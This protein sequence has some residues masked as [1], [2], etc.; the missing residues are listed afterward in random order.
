M[1]FEEQQVVLITGSSRGLGRAFASYLAAAGARVIVNSTGSNDQGAALV[2]ELLDRGDTAAHVTGRVDSAPDDLIDQAAAQWGRL[3]AVVHNAGIVR[4]KT[5][6]KMSDS[7]WDEVQQV[8]LR[9]AFQLSR[10]A[11]P[12]FEAQG[13]GSLVF[14][15]SAA[16]LYGN[17]GQANYAAAKGGLDGLCR[18]IA[19]EGAASN[20]R[21]NTVAP[22]GA[23][24]LNSGAWDDAR[25]A[26]LKTEYVAPL[27]GYLC[28]PACTASGGLFE[29]SAGVFKQVRWERSIGLSLNVNAPMTLTDMYANWDQVSDF[30]DSEH[31]VDMRSALAGLW[32]AQ[33]SV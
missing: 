25:K 11:W 3:D 10:A 5:L 23:T 30:A 2:A 1:R 32:A 20:I 6:R 29:A 22:L 13:G 26:M 14:I 7:Q 18:T 8:H 16:G 17:F 4:D 15:S 28:H 31:P 21:C 19:M 33:R 12:H 27:I 9:A 24:E